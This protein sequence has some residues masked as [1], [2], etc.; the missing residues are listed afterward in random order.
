VGETVHL[1]LYGQL[2][3]HVSFSELRLFNECSW[4]WYLIKVAGH[5]PT[6]RSFQMDFGKAVHSGME[7]LYG[8]GGGDPDAA[9]QHA[10][11]LYD[12]ALGTIGPLHPTDAKEAERLRGYILPKMFRDCLD[13]PELQGI[14]PLRSELQ[15]MQPIART[16][17]LEVL[18]KGFIDFIFVKRLKTKTVIYIADFKTCQWGWPAKKLQDIEVISQILLYKHFFCK[19]TGADPRNVTP[20][21]ILLKKRPRRTSPKGEL[22]ETFDLSVEVAK[23]GGGPKAT[24]RALEYMQRSISEMHSYSYE[25]NFGA[26]VRSWIDQETDEER[27]ARCPFAGTDLCPSSEQNETLLTVHGGSGTEADPLAQ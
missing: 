1:P 7:V 16:D 14:R 5:T 13:C 19:L 12:E 4:K 8:P 22:P 6:D 26:C 11:R 15:L 25:R 24:E 18:F 21:F 2:K 3:E 9:S 10:L 17:G 23:V 20:A 27:V